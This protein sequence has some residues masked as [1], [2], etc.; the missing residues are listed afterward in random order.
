MALTGSFQ[1]IAV[2]N[3]DEPRPKVLADAGINEPPHSW[4]VIPPKFTLSRHVEVL[5]AINS[6][7]LVVDATE[8]RDEVR[9][10]LQLQGFMTFVTQTWRGGGKAHGRV[11]VSH[12]MYTFGL[13]WE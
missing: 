4:T 3:F 13:A 5:L 1:L 8:A 10:M 2:T 6:T 12:M 7:I 11:Y 9:V